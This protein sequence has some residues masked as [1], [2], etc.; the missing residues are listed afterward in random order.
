MAKLDN[1]YGKLF[2]EAKKSW[3]Q[4]WG[5]ITTVLLIIFIA[6]IILAFMFEWKWTGF[7]YHTTPKSDTV[8]FYPG[9]SLW[10]VLDL[11]IIPAV[12]ALGIWWLNK[13]QRQNEQKITQG[14]QEERLLQNYL[15]IMKELLLEKD[16]RTSEEG[17]EVRSVA[18]ARTLAV[19]REV[20]KTRKES[21]VRFLLESELIGEDITITLK[22][23][24]LE[25][26]RRHNIVSLEGVDLSE[27]HLRGA[28]LKGANLSQAN[29]RKTYLSRAQLDEADLRG[30]DLQR[31]HLRATHL[32][33]AKLGMAKLGE[34][35]LRRANLGKA[36]L[37]WANL[38]KANLR[39][40]DLEGA[41]LSHTDLQGAHLRGAKL[42]GAKLNWANLE[43]ADL[44]EANLSG[45][46]LTGARLTEVVYDK[47]TIWPGNFDPVTA[48]E[49]INENKHSV[50][51][52]D[53][54]D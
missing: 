17:S 8:E 33:G 43:E 2:E 15:D 22:G 30:A 47:K 18:R 16:L 48:G 31:T 34:A 35:D 50:H 53:L 10:D 37:S 39:W 24:K 11:I 27:V 3:N 5:T 21:I 41:D 40:A 45:A 26:H 51:R 23:R 12:L 13:E 28:D 14:Q 38:S 29:L 52:I 42:G 1:F 4:Y 6:F 19:L 49:A 54:I 7:F 9:K 44:R 46:N 25:V 36:N 20:N 32:C